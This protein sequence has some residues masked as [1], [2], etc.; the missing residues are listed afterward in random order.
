LVF[1]SQLNRTFSPP[2]QLSIYD[3][4]RNGRREAERTTGFGYNL[5]EL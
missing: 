4:E 1:V 2:P 5:R 3:S